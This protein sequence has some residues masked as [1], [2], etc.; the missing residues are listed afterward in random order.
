MEFP[1][2]R[3]RRSGA[4]DGTRGK[5]LDDHDR[6]SGFVR[7]QTIRCSDRERI[8]VVTVLGSGLGDGRLTP[9]EFES[10]A[11]A[12]TTA[13]WRS[14]LDELIADLPVE[15]AHR[16][17][18]SLD[19]WLAIA[20]QAWLPAAR[21][22]RPAVPRRRQRPARGRCVLGIIVTAVVLIPVCAGCSAGPDRHTCC[23]DPSP[24]PNVRIRL[25]GSGPPTERGCH[26][27]RGGSPFRRAPTNGGRD[28]GHGID[29]LPSANETRYGI[30][31]SIITVG[32]VIDTSMSPTMVVHRPAALV[33]VPSRLPVALVA[34]LAAAVVVWLGGQFAGSSVPSAVDTAGAA[35]LQ[36]AGLDQGTWS[37]VSDIAR[38][39]A[40][41][42][43]A[44]AGLVAIV[45]MWRRRNVQ[46]A[47]LAVLGPGITGIV[48]TVAKPL[49]GRRLPDGSLSFPSGHTT[50]SPASASCWASPSSRR[51]ERTER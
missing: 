10:R 9:E 50:G 20:G 22:R 48:T 34:V 43:V 7:P 14:D 25:T 21:R 13:R 6:G 47:A 51:T 19:A 16:P 23:T 28:L 27:L 26:F 3:R 24:R 49:V 33:P 11:D 37:D 1:G 40:G 12:A 36:R 31:C 32:L 29:D 45:S 39:T 41:R 4:L 42:V 18:T 2:S 17:T 46:L 5:A 35:A 15:T 38:G 30:Y 8:Q 44:V